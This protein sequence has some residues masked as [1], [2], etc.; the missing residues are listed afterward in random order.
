MSDIFSGR[1]KVTTYVKHSYNIWCL[2][3]D[4][5]YTFVGFAVTLCWL[6]GFVVAK[7][8]WSTFFCWF[9]FYAW[10]LVTERTLLHY[11]FI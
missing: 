6:A 11:G 10:Y 7:G 5:F 2:L 4:V 3:R 8:F 9:P 1:G